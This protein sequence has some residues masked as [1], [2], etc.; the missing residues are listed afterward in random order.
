MLGSHKNILFVN[1][2]VDRLILYDFSLE[3]SMVMASNQR[4]KKQKYKVITKIQVCIILSGW[5]TQR[6]I[7]G[8]NAI[9]IEKKFTED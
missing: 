5:S 3:L 9:K 2:I 7:D 6:K 4:K 1:L 8:T